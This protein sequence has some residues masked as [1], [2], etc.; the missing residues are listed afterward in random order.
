MT[1]S[2]AG[3]LSHEEAL[4]LIPWSIVGRI[5]EDDQR[6]LENHLL[7]C[8]ECRRELT[9]QHSVRRAIRREKSNIEYAPQASLQKLMARID[10]TESATP[11]EPDEYVSS[12]A[13]ATERR[14]ERTP[15]RRWLMA[16]ATLLAVGTG[17]LL[18]EPGPPASPEG[19]AR[20]RTVT[21]PPAQPLRAGQIRAVFA[22]NLTVDE[23]TRIASETRLTIV[24]GPSE[25]GVYTLDV[26][27]GAG[28][29]IGDL[30]EA[31]R[32]DPRV[33]FAEPV[34]AESR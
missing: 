12:S 5:P 26:Q 19:P 7:A 2:S 14:V 18:Y 22:P 16:A 34:I 17:T 21:S 13:P 24:D 33:R 31:L 4:D 23:L 15:W 1:Q 6:R 8:A 30:I 3:P 10:A 28:Q 25:S 9:E 11:A 27:P 32:G 20:F 29:S